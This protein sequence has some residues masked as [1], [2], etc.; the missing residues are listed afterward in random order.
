MQ[1]ILLPLLIS[2]VFHLERH[3]PKPKRCNAKVDKSTAVCHG[4][5]H[6]WLEGNLI[7]GVNPNSFPS[8]HLPTIWT[9]N[10]LSG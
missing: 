9:R 1:Q 5:F 6:L 2:T 3:R 10:S 8:E 4:L 7:S